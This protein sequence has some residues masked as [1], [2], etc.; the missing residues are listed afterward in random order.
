MSYISRIKTW[1]PG[2]ILTASDLNTE[3][4]NTLN[5]QIP[6]P[7]GITR[8]DTLY[9]GASSWVRLVVG[10][11]NQYLRS[12]GTDPGWGALDISHDTSPKLGGALDADNQLITNFKLGGE[13]NANNQKI[14]NLLKITPKAETELTISSGAITISQMTH[15][16]TA[17]SGDTD[18]LDTINGMAAGDIVLLRAA[19]GKTITVR[20]NAG[21][22]WIPTKRNVV[23]DDY[24]DAILIYCFFTGYITILGIGNNVEEYTTIPFIIDGGGYEITTGEKGHLQVD[25][26]GEIVGVTALADQSGSIVVDIW[27]D[28]YANFPP[29]NDD[30]ITA[31]APVT[32]SSAQKS[33]D[34][35]LTGWTKTFSAGDAFAFNVDSCTTIERVLIS[36]KV[37]RT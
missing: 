4:D 16:V 15:K 25:F 31:S 34:T 24:N 36:L 8:G 11:A 35:T 3:F 22:I 30:S 27:K 6:E 18:N 20:H 1:I 29:T 9:R 2:E 13:A 10:S 23:L 12:D 26:D 21:N 19:S 32:I 7:A 17:E 28:T 14:T 5:S 37:K 33:E